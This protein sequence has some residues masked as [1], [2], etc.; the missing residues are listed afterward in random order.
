MRTLSSAQIRN[1][2]CTP[3]FDEQIP[4]KRDEAWPKI[5]VVTPS[6]NQGQFLERTILSI[7]NQNYPNLEYIIMDGGSTDGSV[8]IIKKYEAYLAGWVSEK[9]EGQADAV[10]KGFGRCSGQLLAFFNSDDVYLPGTLL[11]VGRVFRANPAIGVVYGNK[12]LIDKYD[13][14]VGERRL[15][16]YVPYLSKFGMLYGGFGIYQPAAFWT[17]HVYQRVGGIDPAFEFAMDTDLT[18]RIALAGARFQFLREFFMASRIHTDSK[19]S[20]IRHVARK[21]GQVIRERY[22]RYSSRLLSLGCLTALRTARALLHIAQGDGLYLLKRRVQ[23]HLA[24][25]P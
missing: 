2:V 22:C 17:R 19:T 3:T 14:I 1:F 4:I 12:Y 9:D 7:L 15:T 8:D 5:S 10:R 21:E 6:Y 20:T 16:A 24:W 25:V 23:T 18:L 13:Q 11:R